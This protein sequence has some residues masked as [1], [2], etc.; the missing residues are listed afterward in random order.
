MKI[1]LLLAA[2]LAAGVTGTAHAECRM[3]G[4]TYAPG[5]STRDH[6]GTRLYCNQFGNWQSAPLVT[7]RPQYDANGRYRPI[8]L[9]PPL[10]SADY[11]RY[12]SDPSRWAYRPPN[13]GIRVIPGTP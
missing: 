10:G 8:E 13:G 7:I 5:A 2:M 9:P 3:F 4:T 11:Y 1:R 6:A 12:W